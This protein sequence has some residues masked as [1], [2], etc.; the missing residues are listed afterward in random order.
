MTIDNKNDVW[1]NIT[2]DA[3]SFE[4]L[5]TEGGK[6]LSELIRATTEMDKSDPC[7]TSKILV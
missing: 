4:S 6:E 1:D 7:A 5:S 3:K 2:A